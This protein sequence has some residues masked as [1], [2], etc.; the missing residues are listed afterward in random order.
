MLRAALSQAMVSVLLGAA[1]LLLVGGC[2]GPQGP[3]GPQGPEGPPG[4]AAGWKS[5]TVEVKGEAGPIPADDWARSAFVQYPGADEV[6]IVL[7][8]ARVKT[9]TGI[10]YPGGLGTLEARSQAT[11]QVETL[12]ELGEGFYVLAHNG[13]GNKVES[14]TVKWWAGVAPAE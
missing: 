9:I 6:P 7:R 13:A 1:A 12:P 14:I 8:V 5:G 3:P 11:A 2:K 4:L 10:P